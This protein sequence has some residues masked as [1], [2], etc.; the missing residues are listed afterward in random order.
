MISTVATLVVRVATHQHADG[1][2]VERLALLHVQ[3]QAACCRAAASSISAFCSSSVSRSPKKLALGLQ[4]RDRPDLLAL[5]RHRCLRPTPALERLGLGEAGD[6]LL[7]G[8]E[9]VEHQRQLGDHEDVLDALVHARTAS[10]ALRAARSSACAEIST[11]SAVEF[12]CC[13]S[14]RLMIRCLLPLSIVLLDRAIE[15]IGLVPAGQVTLRVE[16][17]DALRPGAAS[18]CSSSLGA[19]HTAAQHL[20]ALARLGLIRIERQRPLVQH[21]SPCRGYRSSDSPAPATPTPA[22]TADRAPPTVPGAGSPRPVLLQQ[23]V[24]AELR[25]RLARQ[26]AGVVQRHRAL[27]RDSRRRGWSSAGRS[28]RPARRSGRPWSSPARWTASALSSASGYR[29]ELLLAQ[30]R[31][32]SKPRRSCGSSAIR[33]WNMRHGAVVVLLAETQLASL[34]HAPAW[35][36]SSWNRWSSM[37]W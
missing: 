14:L 18:A 33:R 5:D 29:F 35:R 20:D 37:A 32:R 17:D 24:E 16:N 9:H 3:D 4:D 8:R 31:Y 30:A 36:S 1:D 28:G 23:P 21:R 34:V 11:P 15:L 27:E 7:L 12:R 25:A 19:R 13:V 10:S 2:R 6:R 26:A 22:R